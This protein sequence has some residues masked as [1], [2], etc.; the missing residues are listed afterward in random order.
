MLAGFVRHQSIA[1]SSLYMNDSWPEAGRGAR[2][3]KLC[4]HRE[5]EKGTGTDMREMS[6]KECG[7]GM[8]TDRKR[9]KEREKER[10]RETETERED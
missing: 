6:C 8:H 3:T 2:S 5:G 4:A 10:K 9:E 7:E 1:C